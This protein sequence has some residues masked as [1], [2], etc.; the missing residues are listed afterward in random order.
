M[1]D[2]ERDRL[3]EKLAPFRDALEQLLAEHEFVIGPRS[4]EDVLDEVRNEGQ[5]VPS[6]PLL[7]SEW[8]ICLAWVDVDTGD[9]WTTRIAAPR[10][11]EYRQGGLMAQLDP[12]G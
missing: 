12:L 5:A 4:A 7:V 1:T 9:V 8:V 11:P 2:E 6:K 10:M 3:N